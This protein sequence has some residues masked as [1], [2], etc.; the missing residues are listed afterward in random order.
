[1]HSSSTNAQSY[2]SIF[3][4]TKNFGEESLANYANLIKTG[5]NNNGKFS[6]NISTNYTNHYEKD[7][8][9]ARYKKFLQEPKPNHDSLLKVKERLSF[10]NI[11]MNVESKPQ[12]FNNQ[13]LGDQIINDFECQN[14]EL[15][16]VENFQDADY[17]YQLVE[18]NQTY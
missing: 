5:L 3:K 18:K 8:V 12:W 15:G 13:E 14:Q 6:S 10:D 1:M 17:E 9:L 2:E 16:I 7:S 11:N 4:N